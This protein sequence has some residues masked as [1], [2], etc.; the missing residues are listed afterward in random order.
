MRWIATLATLSYLVVFDQRNSTST[1]TPCQATRMSPFPFSIGARSRDAHAATPVAA[2][3]PAARYFTIQVVDADT[4]RGI[5]LVYLKTT[6]KAVYITDSAGYVAFLEPGLMTGDALWVAISSYGFEPPRG[7]LGVAGMQIHPTAGGSTVIRLKRTQIAQRLYRMTGYGI[8]RDSVLLGKPVPIAKPVLNAKVAGSDTIQCAK[9][10]GKLFWM[11]QDTDRMAFELGNFKMTGATTDLPERLNPDQGLN[12]KYLTV[13]DKP[14]EFARELAQIP[15][16]REGPFPLW[17]DGLTVVPD[18][19][20]RECLVGRYYAA[21]HSM[22]CVEV[23][24]LKCTSSTICLLHSSSTFDELLKMRRQ[25]LPVF[26]FAP[27]TLTLARN[28][29]GRTHHME[30]PEEGSRKASQISI[31]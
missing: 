8:Y 22:G 5:P 13:G 3:D 15:L 31:Q 7:F 24:I 19:Y 6:Y 14:D 23:R 17:I 12:F 9:F 16:D 10:Q 20:G 29:L 28:V 2:D 18:D 4:N 25:R 30:R 1:S 26:S 27:S 21:D 11:W